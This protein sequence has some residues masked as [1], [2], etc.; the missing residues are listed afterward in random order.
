MG[1]S[2]GGGVEYRT[3]NWN[4]FANI[5]FLE[6]PAGVGF[7]YSKAPYTPSDSSTALDNVAFVRG[8][9]A[10]YPEFAQAPIWLTGESYAGTYVPLLARELTRSSASPIY[11]QLAGFMVGTQRSRALYVCVCGFSV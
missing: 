9:L 5:V 7:S 1:P 3:I 4:S 11:A 8:F 10:R 6:S 2:R